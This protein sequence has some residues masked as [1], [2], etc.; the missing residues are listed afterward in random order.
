MPS[1]HFGLF[2]VGG[3]IFSCAK[4]TLFGRNY[5]NSCK[6]NPWPTNDSAQWSHFGPFGKDRAEG[7]WGDPCSW[8]SSSLPTD[9]LGAIWLDRARR[10]IRAHP[11][12]L[13]AF[14]KTG[15]FGHELTWQRDCTRTPRFRRRDEIGQNRL[16]RLRACMKPFLPREYIWQ[17][18][19]GTRL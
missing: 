6:R 11:T 10:K 16:F 9:G 1:P 4:S 12:R 2:S 3:A 8:A 17:E 7:M 14:Q 18:S 15:L 19:A 5:R 13:H